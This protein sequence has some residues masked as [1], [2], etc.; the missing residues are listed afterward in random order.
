MRTSTWSSIA[1]VFSSHDSDT[2]EAHHDCVARGEVL[3][4]VQSKHA[5]NVIDQLNR[6][7]AEKIQKNR[8]IITEIIEI[9]I[10]IVK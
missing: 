6:Q 4:R 8:N 10:L 1:K 9:F 5:I 2:N 7:R 3:S